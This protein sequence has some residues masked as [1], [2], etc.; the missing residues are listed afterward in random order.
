MHRLHRGSG[1][2]L[3]NRHTPI[4]TTPLAINKLQILVYLVVFMVAFGVRFLSWQDNHRDVLKVETLVTSDY[5]DSARQLS[6]GDLRAFI[7]D[8]NHMEHPPGYSILI[9]GIFRTVGESN[10]AIQ[11]FQ[12]AAD[13]VAALIALVIAFELVPVSAPIAGFL[14]ALSPQL[15]YYSLL[16]LPDSITAVPILLSVYL[17]ILSCKRPRMLTFILSGG[18][19]GI[20]CWLR[21]NGLLLAPFLAAVVPITV[22]RGRRLRYMAALE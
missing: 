12:I 2:S 9:A 8:L 16:L 4:S 22:G 19:V 5:E 21:P 10:T 18:L 14:V 17:L 20:S 3:S 13:S 1:D 7:S 6:G 11:F 15:S